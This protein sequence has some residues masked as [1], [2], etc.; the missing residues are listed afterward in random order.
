MRERISPASP[1]PT[2]SGLMMARVRSRATRSSED[3]ISGMNQGGINP[4]LRQYLCERSTD[5]GRALHAVN[6]RGSHDGVLFLRRAGSAADDG[7]GVT[8]TAAGRR[9]LPGDEADH[10]LLH[11]CLDIGGRG[12]FGIAA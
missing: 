5:I 9:G 10:G 6:S 2:A 1:R 4:P 3:E 12:F 7:A 11:V 8:H